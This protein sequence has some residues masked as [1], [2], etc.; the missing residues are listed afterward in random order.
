MSAAWVISLF[1]IVV[2]YFLDQSKN[3]AL[4]AVF[5]WIPAVLLAYVIPALI[6]YF[7]SVDYSADAIHGFSKTWV[8]PMAIVA[9]MSSLSFAQL[10]AIGFKPIVLF[11]IGSAIIALFPVVFAWGFLDSDLVQNQWIKA[12]YWKGIPPIVGS[13]IGGSTSQLVLKEL[14]KTSESLFLQV[15]VIDTVLVNIWTIF[16]FQI[17]KKSH[18]LNTFFNISDR[19]IPIPIAAESQKKLPWYWVLALLILGVFLV[20]IF[21]TIFVVKVIALLLIVWI[22]LPHGALDGSIA[23]HL[24]AGRSFTSVL[25]FLFLYLLCS[26]V[27][28]LIWYKFSAL[29][30]SLFLI[31]SMLMEI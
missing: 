24:G 14:A 22:G 15:L 18:K 31:I 30:L 11:V 16:M 2:V 26:V 23:M 17:I 5:D 3:K 6:S 21:L 29:S 25:Q 10:K 12:N 1:T 13:W 28:V 27:V 9:V 20:E 8:I 4:A 7:F 19:T